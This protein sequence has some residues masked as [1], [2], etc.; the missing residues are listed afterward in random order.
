MIINLRCFYGYQLLS[1]SERD[2]ICNGAGAA[3]DWRSRLIPNT[4]YGLDCI[5]AFNIHDHG[6]HV[7]STPQ[8]KEAADFMMLYN[9]LKI[10]AS[11]SSWLAPLRNRRALK[12]F[13]AVV[14]AGEDAFWTNKKPNEI[15]YR[16]RKTYEIEYYV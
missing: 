2:N 6:Y 15:Q 7:G 5:E 16:T 14:V 11:G 4:L 9:L 13:E 1:K 8:D 3:N 10:I 12:Y